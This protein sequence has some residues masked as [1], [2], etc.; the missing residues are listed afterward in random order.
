MNGSSCKADMTQDKDNSKYDK[1]LAQTLDT[2]V[3]KAA[4]IEVGDFWL[5][6][7]ILR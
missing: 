5:E 3:A 6:K 4:Y 7:S 2:I 1:A